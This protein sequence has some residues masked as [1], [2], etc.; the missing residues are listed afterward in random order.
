MLKRLTLRGFTVFREAEIEFAPGINVVIGENGY[1]KS[2]LLKLGYCVNWFSDRL[3]AAPLE[4][5]DMAAKNRLL[6]RK[7]VGVFRPEQLGRL[8][9]RG[10]GRSRAEVVVDYRDKASAGFAFSFASN[11]KFDVSIDRA[12]KKPIAAPSV[13]LPTKEVMSMYPGFTAL[14]RDYHLQIDET[15][16]DLCLALER[17]LTRGPKE[18]QL[19]PLLEPIEEI[20]EGKVVNANGRFMLRQPGRGNMEMPLVAEGFRKLAAVAYL[21]ANGSLRN[22]AALFWD[23]PETNLNARYIKRVASTLTAVAKKGVQVVIATHSLFLLRELELSL[24]SKQFGDVSRR[25]IA[26]GGEP[27]DVVVSQAEDISGVEPILALD[28]ELEQTDRYL[29]VDSVERGVPR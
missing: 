12:P 1:G 22:Q 16:Y 5:A 15:Y 23:E 20:L 8:A 29:G 9:R 3:V 27:G 13:F 25:F 10:Q 28:E 19:R 21:I 17:P 11:S 2:H 7:L 24:G 14:Y 6:G 18:A 26:L 4:T